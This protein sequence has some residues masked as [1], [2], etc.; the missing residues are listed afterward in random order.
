MERFGWDSLNGGDVF[1]EEAKRRDMSLA[2]FGELCK[3]ELDVDRSLDALLKERM[4]GSD[5]AN[6]VNLG[7]A[8]WWAYRLHSV[9]GCGS[10]S[11]TRSVLG[12]LRIARGWR[13]K[14]R[15]RRTAFVRPSTVHGFGALYD[16]TPEGPGTVHACG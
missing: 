11:T 5:P 2:A 4:Q 7:L 13:L 8:G 15:P 3:N 14:P 16:L 6:V 1:R 10:T 12:V 9:F